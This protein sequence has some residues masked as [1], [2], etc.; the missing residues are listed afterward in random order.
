MEWLVIAPGLFV[1]TVFVSL[2]DLYPAVRTFLNFR[3]PSYYVLLS[4]GF[5]LNLF[6]AFALKRTIFTEPGHSVETIFLAAFATLSVIQSFS[7]KLG[8]YK[9]INISDLVEG[10]RGTVLA[11]IAEMK[12][13]MKRREIQ[14]VGQKLAEKFENQEGRLITEYA[15]LFGGEAKIQAEVEELRGLASKGGFGFTRLLAQRI[16]QAD[17]ARAK[18]V[19]VSG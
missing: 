15:V 12:T 16:A 1:I 9:L 17:L 5:A 8:N 2:L 6:A 19:L 7:L 10:F 4:V 14:Q 3:T 11:D 13:E 18:D